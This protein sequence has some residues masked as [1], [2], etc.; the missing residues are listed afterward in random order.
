MASGS[1][2]K[3]LDFCWKWDKDEYEK[4]AEKR[5]T[6]EREKKDGKPVRPVKR[7]LLRH[8]D[9]KVDLESK[10]RKTTVITKTT[11]RS[12]PRPPHGLRWDDTTAMSVKVWW[13]TPSTSWITLMERNISETWACLCVW[14]IPLWIRWRNVLKSTRRKWKRR[15]KIMILRKGWRNSEK[16]RKRP[17]P[18]RKR[19]RRRRKGGRR[20]TWH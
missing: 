17:K 20:R 18:T 6:E 12:L 5:L 9:Y 4:L 15:R 19:N 11:P 8:R 2:T 10:L 3:N 1:G 13:K 7:E 14:D 16:R